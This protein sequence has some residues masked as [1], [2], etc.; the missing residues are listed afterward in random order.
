MQ[1]ELDGKVALVTGGAKGIGHATAEILR[2]EG[3]QV[4]SV[5]IDA[6]AGSGSICA[7]ISKAEECER[8]VNIAQVL[9]GGLDILVNNAGIQTY[10]DALTTSEE[11]WNRTMDVNL[12][13]QWLMA[14]A[15]LPLMLR[16]GGGSIVNVSSVQGLASQKNV[17]AYATSKHALIGL[18]RTMAVDFASRRI[19]VNCVCPGTV[20]TPMVRA[21]IASDHHPDRLRNALDAMHPLGR[22]AAPAEVGEVIAFLVSDRASFVTGTVMTVDGGLLVPLAGSPE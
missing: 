4:I 11:T 6:P 20:D 3:A 17:L 2:R 10:G 8:A 12:K 15:A 13:G 16:R 22:I 9:Y 14:K 7:D 1:H 19:R 18:T 5:D 21:T